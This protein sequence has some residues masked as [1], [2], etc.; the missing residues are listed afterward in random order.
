MEK[1]SEEIKTINP[2]LKVKVVTID[3][4]N[5][6]D[7]SSITQDSEVMSNLGIVVNNAGIM[8]QRNFFDQDPQAKQS[9]N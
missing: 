9:I 4:A 3:L 7:Y 6:S 5:T 2:D 1:V 8:V